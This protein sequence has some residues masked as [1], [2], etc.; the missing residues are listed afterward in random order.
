MREIVTNI[1][2]KEEVLVDVDVF[3]GEFYIAITDNGNVIFPFENTE[4]SQK[5]SFPM[6]RQI[7][8]DSFLIANSRISTNEENCF[9]YDRKGKL[10]RKFLAGDAIQDIEV[11][12]DKIVVTYFD[13]GVYGR[14]GPNSEGLVIFD[15][16]GN[17][18][19]QYN[20]KHG[21]QIISDC[22]CICKHG[23]NRVLLLPYTDFPLI[24]LNLYTE[25]EN[26]YEVPEILKGST[27]LS[28]ME[29]EIFFHSPYHDKRGIYQWRIGDKTTEKIG[30][31]SE[32]LRGLKNGRF[33]S[34][35]QKGFTILDFN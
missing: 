29:D 8:Q 18:V 10:I 27:G 6:I 31:Y 17:I 22:Y 12:R 33:L 28:S 13:E 2:L 5:F 30:E 9:I 14:E 25:E 21:E 3:E 24:E 1:E 11:I 7:N 20:T 34:K 23:T 4:L 19:F 35:G 15:W 26:R 16:N 32:G